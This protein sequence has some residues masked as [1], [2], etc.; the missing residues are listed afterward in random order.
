MPLPIL[1]AGV[2]AAGSLL[3]NIFGN[4][5]AKRRQQKANKQN[6]KF[7]NLQNE[8]NTPSAQM[9]RLKD[10]GLNPNLIYGGSTGQASGMAEKIAPAKAADYNID[11]PIKDVSQFADFQVKS[12]TT[13]NLKAQ[14]DLIIQQQLLTANQTEGVGITNAQKQLE[15]GISPEML[16]TQLSALRA[17]VRNIE[18]KTIETTINNSIKSQ[19]VQM[20]VKDI[21][22]RVQNAK[23]NLVGT[24][25]T[26]ELKKY[27]VELNKLG[28]Q[29]TDNKL[30]R[31]I[32]GET[33]NWMDSTE[34]LLKSKN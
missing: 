24:K 29:K 27:E 13:D 23:A 25:L 28:I 18:A 4:I 3:G 31:L 34:K 30:F 2:G 12:A 26:N 8:Y 19:A 17:N 5:G 20:L 1:A 16:K 9:A 14:N 32:F 22:Y 11:N 33:F 21:Y 15:L 6:I 10:A 7:W